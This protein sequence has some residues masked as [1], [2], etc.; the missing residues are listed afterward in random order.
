MRKIFTILL[1]L[2]LLFS[3]AYSQTEEEIITGIFEMSGNI[4]SLSTDLI[5][6]SVNAVWLASELTGQA[7]ITGTL[8]QSASNPNYWSYSP[9]P[10]DKLVL[11][12]ASGA[13]ISFTFNSIN[14]YTE[15]D[16]ED[17]I[18]SHYMDFVSVANNSLNLRIVSNTQPTKTTII[19]WQRSITGLATFDDI[20][21]NFSIQHNG[22]KEY[23]ISGGYA[24]YEYNETVSGTA[25][26][27]N[28]SATINDGMHSEIGMNSNTNV[29]VKSTQLN[30]ASS[31]TVNNNNY[32]FSNV[33]VTWHAGTHSEE[34]AEN[35]YFNEVI[36]PYNWSC[37]GTLLKNNQN[38]GTVQ[39]SGDII[40]GTSGPYLIAALNN[41]N[42]ILLHPLLNLYVNGINENEI[43]NKDFYL[44]QNYPNPFNPTTTIKYTIP[45][46]IASEP[47]LSGERS[48]L[49]NNTQNQQIV[50]GTL[51]A[52]NLT[53][54]N[55]R[56]DANVQLVVYDILGRKVATLVNK[57]QA[58][59]NYSVLFN[60]SNLPSGVYFYTLR[61]GNFVATKK[62]ILLK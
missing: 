5:E 12:F 47:D 30:S 34:N 49:S 13:S 16:A 18:N 61:V 43:E 1:G 54:S 33:S 20:P 23:D 9:S 8:T 58:P 6:L 55:S 53:S 45:S 36:E 26:A 35:D 19:N 56:N 21:Y 51:R 42:Q 14:G 3:V 46:V 57:R 50:H 4:S 32:K 28:V 17:F 10:N 60:A 37:S 41:G 62:M 39:F 25:T 2:N 15:G 11:I 31:V 44:A 22:S 59:G 38:Y 24:F 48:N 40:E 29:F 7:T 52:T 27:S